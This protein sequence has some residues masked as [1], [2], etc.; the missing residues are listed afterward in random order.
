M[1]GAAENDDIALGEQVEQT[2]GRPDGIDARR[3]RLVGAPANR[4]DLEPERR[5]D[6]HQFEA[7]RAEADNAHALPAERADVDVG[8]F[9][10][11]CAQRCAIC[12]RIAAGNL[13]ASAMVTPSTCSAISG[14]GCR[15]RW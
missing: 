10:S 6:L 14:R 12:A 4:R 5:R 11:A 15:V 7:D 8:P 9:D 1:C 2:V 3:R 13:R